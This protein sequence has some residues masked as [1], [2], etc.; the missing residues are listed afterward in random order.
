MFRLVQ[1]GDPPELPMRMLFHP[2]GDGVYLKACEADGMRGLVAALLN[3]PAYEAA[4]PQS[5][6]A[7][8]LRIANDIA[9]LAELDGRRLE[10]RDREGP[11]TIVIASDEPLLY[12][13]ERLGFVSLSAPGAKR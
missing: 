2:V 3:D 10:I 1:P 5:R 12:S 13:L 11:E 9:L 4:D 8:R 6:L 7:E